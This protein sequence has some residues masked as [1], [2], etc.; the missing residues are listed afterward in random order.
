MPVAAASSIEHT[1]FPSASGSADF[2]LAQSVLPEKRRADA[3]LGVL[4]ITKWFGETSGG[5]RTYLLQ[6][7]R[8]VEARP[9]LRH[10][11][12]IPGARDAI[13]A[14]NGV[15][16]YRLR[17]P[18]IPTQHP[19][20]FLLATRSIRR[21]IEHERPDVIEVGSPFLV[22]WITRRAARRY[23]V[24][25]VMFFHSNFPRAVCAT[26][27][28]AGAVR[29]RAAGA[30]WRYVRRLNKEFEATIVASKFMAE[31][32]EHHG[33]ERVVQIP[34]GVDLDHFHPSRKAVAAAA[35]A[36]AGLP[37]D[38]P[39]VAFVGRFSNEKE[40]P[41]YPIRAWAASS[42]GPAPI[43][44]WWVRGRRAS[45][46]RRKRAA[47]A[48]F[49]FPTRT[50]GTSSRIFSRRSISWYRPDPFRPSVFR[51]S[52]RWRRARRCSPPTAVGSSSRFSDLAVV[53]SSPRGIRGSLADE[54]VRLLQ[55]P[56]TC[57]DSACSD[58]PTPSASIPGPACS[59]GS[60]TSTAAS[61]PP[62]GRPSAVAGDRGRHLLVSIHDVTPALER[63]VRTLWEMCRGQ[64]VIPALLVVPDWHGEWPLGQFP[65]FIQWLRE[66]AH[67]GA[68]IFL[69]G[70]RHD[71]VGLPRTPRDAWRAWGK[72]A[73]E[74]EFLT[75]DE[76]AAR[77]RIDRG[78]R[79]S[80][81]WGSSR[82]DSC[83][84]P[85]S[86]VLP[87][88]ARLPVPGSDSARTT[89]RFS[90]TTRH[91]CGASSPVVRW[92]SRT[93]IRAYGS[94][95]VAALRWR[96]QRGAPHVRIALHPS[97]LDHAATARSVGKGW[98]SGSRIG[99]QPG[100]RTCDNRRA[101][102]WSGRR[103]RG[104]RMRR[105][106]QAHRRHAV[107][108][109]R[110][111]AL[112]RRSGS[113]DAHGIDAVSEAAAG[114]ANGTRPPGAGE[115]E[116]RLALFTDTYLPQLN[117]VSRTLDRLVGAVRG[118]GGAARVYTTTDPRAD[119]ASAAEQDVWRRPSVPFWAYPQLR[120]AGPGR[121][122]IGRDLAAWRPTLIHAATPFGMGL[123]GQWCARAMG[124]PLVTS[125]HTSFS[126][127]AK[128]YN[129]GWLRRVGDPV[130]RSFHNAGLRTYVPTR[131][132]YRELEGLGFERLAIWGR[133]IDPKR[134][135]PS[136]RSSAWRARLG[137]DDDTVV[138]AY[139]GRLAAEKGLDVAL[140]AMHRLAD[141][142][143]G[144]ADGASPR[145]VFALAGDGPYDA[146]CRRTAPP[147]PAVHFV[148][149]LEGRALSEFYASADIFIFPSTTD[150]FGNVLLEAMASGLPVIAADVAPTRE[151]LARGGG[152]AIPP[153]DAAA[154]ADM[155]DA[156]SRNPARRA[157]LVAA[158]SAFA[159]TCSWD[160]IFNEL[161]ADYR[162][163]VSAADGARH[164]RVAE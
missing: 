14:G 28:R 45:V 123:T 24:P 49:G 61:S 136:F 122:R 85:G 154:M 143:P 6:K 21:I 127:Y 42:A 75:L 2:D 70:Q 69:H 99:R 90:R 52:R 92:S 81:D 106:Y 84:P 145:I 113:R 164:E 94:T 163:V 38:T 79:Y 139:V 86:P 126:E 87:A 118:R 105:P 133:G 88:I 120:L 15:R 64:G 78:S 161:L 59:T 37:A 54:A 104:R 33:A 116:L 124:T 77:E 114:S 74:G 152:I 23:N 102:R 72:T 3:D 129:L 25:L 55:A 111:S 135:S 98:T 140:G 57:L 117:G 66:C 18:R 130:I 16:C 5:V 100:T 144:G 89:A 47:N 56:P 8:Y 131:A 58:V 156:L 158:G 103:R 35:R 149:A 162:Q 101:R 9:S 76:H 134:F 53:H 141:R 50:T 20:R 44:R 30:L 150:T 128:F 22:P 121:G 146:H 43:W 137:A 51:R 41:V 19:Y 95:A 11:L 32:L 109:R 62:S 142:A 40:V 65:A 96:A 159:S 26:P 71:E 7:A 12:V 108:R 4:D 39:V 119:R 132:I 73:R 63:N 36:R 27:E 153:R 67:A 160:R 1:L 13:T 83:L 110:P 82:S 97:D 60:L 48:S 46:C 115:V 31:D 157:E 151:L 34:L 93:P 10:V 17:G 125:Y 91:R 80:P 29:R 68:E 138:V 112:E 155:I 107:G 148:G 147:P